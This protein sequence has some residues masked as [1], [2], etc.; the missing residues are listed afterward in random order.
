M[1][2]KES[3]NWE[4]D[5]VERACSAWFVSSESSSIGWV[6]YVCMACDW[7]DRN[8]RIEKF[9]SLYEIYQNYGH[10][11]PLYYAR[12]YYR[13][14]T[15]LYEYTG[16]RTYII[17][18][19]IHTPAQLQ[20]IF[21]PSEIECSIYYSVLFRRCC[22][23]ALS[24]IRSYYFVISSDLLPATWLAHSNW[25]STRSN[26]LVVPRSPPR[27]KLSRSAKTLPRT[28]SLQLS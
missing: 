22:E 1:W 25:C 2:R 11:A 12:V 4:S 13:V 7:L 27:R 5:R 23:L 9:V 8:Y 16:I 15:V 24:V 6:P 26:Q 10:S 20:E 18:T 21:M 19:Y 17:N 28:S 14:R 3:W